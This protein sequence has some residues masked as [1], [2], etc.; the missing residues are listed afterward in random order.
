MDEHSAA[1]IEQLGRIERFTRVADVFKQIADTTRIRI[2]WLL[3]H[4]E[5]CVQSISALMSMT[6]PAVSH[7][8]RALRA[9]GLVVSRREGR[10][11]YYRASDTEVSELLHQMT[12]RIMEITCP[13]V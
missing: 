4:S 13:E 10:E 12:E 2:F 1:L 6:S 3:C 8:L 5:E 7:H 11:V 9:S